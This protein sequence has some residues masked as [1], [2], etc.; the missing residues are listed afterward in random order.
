MSTSLAKVG[1]NLFCGVQVLSEIL[2]CLREGTLAPFVASIFS[3]LQFWQPI[4]RAAAQPEAVELHLPPQPVVVAR[5]G[6]VQPLVHR[7]LDVPDHLA[8]K[9]RGVVHAASGELRVRV[10]PDRLVNGDVGLQQDDVLCLQELSAVGEPP[11]K[12][13][14]VPARLSGRA[15]AVVAVHL[16][17]H[18]VLRVR[19]LRGVR[20]RVHEVSLL[21]LGRHRQDVRLRQEVGALSVQHVHPHRVPGR[22]IK[23]NEKL[24]C[25]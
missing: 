19:V 14:R 18:V 4:E 24:S 8:V 20:H 16:Q 25:D 1:L 13:P 5:A 10:E 7:L 3:C 11:Q 21:G 15:Q 12:R 17:V 23:L 6:A 2:R 22:C 9:A